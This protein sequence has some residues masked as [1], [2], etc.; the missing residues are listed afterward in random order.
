MKIKIYDILLKI[1][2]SVMLVIVIIIVIIFIEGINVYVVLFSVKD[3]GFII[4]VDIG[5]GLV[6]IINKVNGDMIL[7]KFNGIEF[8]VKNK[9]L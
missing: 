2:I 3:N 4:V 1:V 8:N 9:V 6:Y 5:L 7:C